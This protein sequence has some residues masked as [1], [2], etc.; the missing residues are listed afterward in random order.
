MPDSYNNKSTHLHFPLIVLW[1]ADGCPHLWLFPP[2]VEKSKCPYSL[3]KKS[4][5][6]IIW[7][8]LAPRDKV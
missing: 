7:E 1:L 5:I 6:F 2:T 8:N 4:L 3:S